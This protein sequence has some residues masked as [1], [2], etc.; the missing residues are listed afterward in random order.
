MLLL[1]TCTFRLNGTASSS[2]LVLM[3]VLFYLCAALN[4]CVCVRVCVCVCV[5]VS[6][7]VDSRTALLYFSLALV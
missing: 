2:E 7:C 3:A 4:V 6:L 1:Y 5:C